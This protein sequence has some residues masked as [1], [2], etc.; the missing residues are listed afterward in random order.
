MKKKD[1]CERDFRHV[2][3]G[4]TFG[5]NMIRERN[6]AIHEKKEGAVSSR[7]AI[8]ASRRERQWDRK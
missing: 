1:I 6:W 5:E 2:T 3:G 7:F 8:F 4:K